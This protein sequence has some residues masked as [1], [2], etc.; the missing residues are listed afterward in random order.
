MT[1]EKYHI[2]AS[3]IF[4]RGRSLQTS[5][6]EDKPAQRSRLVITKSQGNCRERVAQ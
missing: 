2:I 1:V 4:M 6:D 5:D 3:N